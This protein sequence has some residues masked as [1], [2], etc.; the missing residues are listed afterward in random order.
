MYI[1][2]HHHLW[3]FDPIEYD[4]ID[5]SMAVLKQ[6]FQLK[7]LEKTLNE[8]G[9]SGSIVVQARQS[10]QETLWLADL[11]AS[12]ISLEVWLAGLI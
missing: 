9:F 1:D 10:M 6:D 8:N 4:W 3:A 2:A 5:D 12:Q 7:E 11:E